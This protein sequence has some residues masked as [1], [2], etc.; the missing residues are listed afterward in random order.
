MHEAERDEGARVERRDDLGRRPRRLE[1]HVLDAPRVLEG[2][3]QPQRVEALQALAR[4]AAEAEPRA[5]L[6]RAPRRRQPREPVRGAVDVLVLERVDDGEAAVVAQDAQRPE[7][8]VQVDARRARQLLR[9]P[10]AV[11]VRDDLLDREVPGVVA[12]P[13][14]REAQE[15]ARPREQHGH[16]VGLDGRRRPPLVQAAVHDRGPGAS[17]A[18]PGP[19]EGQDVRVARRGPRRRRRRRDVP[20]ARLGRGALQRLEDGRQRRLQSFLARGP[21]RVLGL[22]LE[23][24]Q[25]PREA[26]QRRQAGPRGRR[27]VR[28]RHRHAQ[29][30]EQRVPHVARLAPQDLRHAE[31]RVPPRARAHRHAVERLPARDHVVAEALPDA[32]ALLVPGQAA[33]RLLVEDHRALDV[34]ELSIKGARH[35]GH[36][37]NR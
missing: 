18:E 14:R 19:R 10:H 2:A 16:L 25:G 34:V 8:H 28:A 26:L 24:P 30:E 6:Q 11:D 13:V 17:A 5:A 35:A 37:H 15:V 12:V 21:R 32:P 7:H 27:E 23:R 4:L 36:G 9:G 1:Q 29:P 20:P 3:V 31:H 22:R 33:R